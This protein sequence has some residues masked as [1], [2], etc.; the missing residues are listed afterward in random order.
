MNTCKFTYYGQQGIY[1]AAAWVGV[2]E[3]RKLWVSDHI[4]NCSKEVPKFLVCPFYQMKN[5]SDIER[6]RKE[7]LFQRKFKPLLNRDLHVG[8]L[9]SIQ[10]CIL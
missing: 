6:E 1:S 9:P 10:L 5:S 4:D 3:T 8:I 7:S 2:P